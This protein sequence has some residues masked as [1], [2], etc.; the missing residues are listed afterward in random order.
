MTVNLSAGTIDHVV[1]GVGDAAATS[2]IGVPVYIVGL[3]VSFWLPA[4]R[5]AGGS[6][7]VQPQRRRIA[8][9][10]DAWSAAAS[11]TA[12]SPLLVFTK[13]PLA[14]PSPPVGT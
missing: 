11:A 1:N 7:D 14:A 5:P 8:D 10:G 9:R 4:V 13:P 2:R 12:C 3:P 6:L